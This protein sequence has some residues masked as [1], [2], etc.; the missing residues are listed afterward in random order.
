M[1]RPARP[2]LG[3]NLEWHG[4]SIRVVLA[5]PP[6]LRGTLG[7]N[8]LRKSLPTAKPKEAEILKLPVL[9]GMRATIAEA[10]RRN[11][12]EAAPIDP[13]LD[14]AL[15]WRDELKNARATIDYEAGE[16]DSP[17][18]IADGLMRDEA[19]GIERQYGE[20]K[21]EAFVRIAEG[22]QTPFEPYEADWLATTPNP[23][24]KDARTLALRRFKEWCDKEDKAKTVE[25]V[26]RSVAGD[27]VTAEY[28]RRDVHP[29]TA[30]KDI[31]ALV[32]FWNY[33]MKKG[34]AESN[35]WL[36][37]RLKKKDAGQA[38][39]GKRPFTD[40]EVSRLLACPRTEAMRDMSLM[41]ALT[42]MRISEIGNLAVKDVQ[43]GTITVRKGKSAAARRTFPQH[44]ALA[45]LI[46]RRTKG[47]SPD[48]FLIE[49]LPEQK[50]GRRSRAAPISQAFTRL[51]RAAKVDDRAEGVRQSG[52]DFHSWRRWF[53]RKAVEAHA[54][55][56]VGFTPWTIADVVGHSSDDGPLG[57]T[58]KRYPGDASIEAK[59][60]CVE[61]VRLPQIAEGSP[62]AS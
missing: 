20:A 4:N 18:E 59:E 44:S 9:I 34:R 47:K 48:A 14:R 21:A 5:V 38:N 23:R 24:T 11:R 58:M 31:G 2:P 50:G 12:P 22:R 32:N 57:L 16:E 26:A 43:D 56:A 13:V 45:A 6:S 46:E 28:E 35:P 3:Q 29:A 39:A 25:A 53:I 41:A 37:Q 49:E 7:K 51:R 1:P 40:E 19:T 17:R 15:M 54:K 62:Q 60:A 52:V 10:L 36:S 27:F 30:N 33:L 55:G 8:K 61:A 42:G